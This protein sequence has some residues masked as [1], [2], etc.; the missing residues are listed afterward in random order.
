MRMPSRSVEL[1]DIISGQILGDDPEVIALVLK[2]HLAL[3]A[4]IIELI[5][6]KES[7]DRTYKL[8]FPDKTKRLLSLNVITSDE[9][10]AFDAFNDFRNDY[11]H[12]FGHSVPLSSLLKLARDLEGY[13]IEFSDSAGRLSEEKAQEYYGYLGLLE[14]VGW[15]ILFHAAHLLMDQGGRNI[16]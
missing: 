12:I 3:E 2:I 4:L 5:Q 11:A 13:G 9:K 7:S 6:T 8:S 1:D 14:E 16:F 10:L 15:C